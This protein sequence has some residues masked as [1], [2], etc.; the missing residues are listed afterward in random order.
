MKST[1]FEAVCFDLDDTLY[2]Y[3]AYART[4]LGAAADHLAERTGERLHDE[5]FALYFDEGVTTGTFDTLLERHDLDPDLAA[6]LVAAYHA[7]TEPLDPYPETPAVLAALARDHALGLVTDGRGGHEKLDRL[8]LADQFDVVLVNHDHGVTK[9]EPEPFERALS[10]L[11]SAPTEAIH[12]GNSLS[13]DV[14][15]AR[16]AGLD[17]AWLDD[18]SDP[19]PVPEYALGTLPELLDR[20]WE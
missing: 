10:A 15:G 9:H 14:E 20:P 18:G 3:E 16:T 2:P 17:A 7:A 1:P 13:S 5:V 6:P 11:D 8:D 12:V 4:G 19:D